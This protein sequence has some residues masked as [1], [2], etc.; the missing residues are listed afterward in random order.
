VHL[1]LV[2]NFLRE[3]LQLKGKQKISSE[4]LQGG[5]PKCN[6][7]T[8]KVHMYVRQIRR[9]YKNAVKL[10][11]TKWNCVYCQKLLEKKCCYIEQSL[12]NQKM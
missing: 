9:K 6:F 11:A 3:N 4:W 5:L 1:V 12:W 10:K 7:W 2:N 8:R